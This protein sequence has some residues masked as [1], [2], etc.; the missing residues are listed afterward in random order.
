MYACVRP[1]CFVVVFDP[2]APVSLAV[3][4][5][6]RSDMALGSETPPGFSPGPVSPLAGPA[7]R[8]APRNIGG[9]AQRRRSWGAEARAAV[10]MGAEL[11][12][13]RSCC[14][15]CRQVF[16]AVYSN[17]GRDFC[18]VDCRCEPGDLVAMLANWML[19]WGLT[20]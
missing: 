1:S 7:L 11:E 14:A 8:S 9:T 3:F 18:G 20:L 6:G 13:R 17:G 2:V 5:G 12:A 10:M 16:L 19:G 4:A 15:H